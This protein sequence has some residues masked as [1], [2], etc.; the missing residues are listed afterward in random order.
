MKQENKKCWSCGYFR[1]YWTRG[2]C[3]L[4]KEKNGLCWKH[5]KVM[6]KS[7]SCEDWNYKLTSKEKRIKIAANCIPE[8]YQKVAVLE[9]LMTEEME[10]EKIRNETDRTE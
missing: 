7:D 6:D 5:N 8:I 1:A 3:C 2:Y 9:Q 10:L 4:M